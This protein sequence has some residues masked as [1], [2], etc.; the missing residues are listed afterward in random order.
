MFRLRKEN[1]DK[2]KC[3]QLLRPT[4]SG[5]E[6]TNIQNH[7]INTQYRSHKNYKRKRRAWRSQCPLFCTVLERN[8]PGKRPFEN[9]NK[10]IREGKANQYNVG[11]L[12]LA[13]GNVVR[14]LIGM[15]TGVQERETRLI[16]FSFKGFLFILFEKKKRTSGGTVT[17]KHSLFTYN[18]P[19]PPVR[20][21]RGTDRPRGAWAAVMCARNVFQT[22]PT[23]EFANKQRVA[24][25]EIDRVQLHS[26]ITTTTTTSTMKRPRQI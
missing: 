25:T 17:N 7:C 4:C 18:H 5:Y 9:P 8:P 3:I 19:P 23:S 14:G 21:C 2:N 22:R 13:G 15:G 26:I 10:T 1:S 16:E 12:N 11:I 20:G 24:N 6:R